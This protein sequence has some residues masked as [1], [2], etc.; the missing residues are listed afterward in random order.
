[1]VELADFTLLG[2]AHSLVQSVIIG[3]HYIVSQVGVLKVVYAKH[4]PSYSQ[5]CK[6]EYTY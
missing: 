6:Y 2:M 1:M 5:D 3:Y 4:G